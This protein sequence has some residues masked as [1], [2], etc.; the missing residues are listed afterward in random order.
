MSPELSGNARSNLFLDVET[1]SEAILTP[2]LRHGKSPCFSPWG[3]LK[4]FGP[5]YPLLVF[6]LR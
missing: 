1:C 3:F 2:M 5:D 4:W 6:A